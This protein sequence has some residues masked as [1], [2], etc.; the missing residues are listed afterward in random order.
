MY[1]SVGQLRGGGGLVVEY[2][3]YWL[4][5]KRGVVSCVSVCVCKRD[6]RSVTVSVSD[7]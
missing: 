2:I 6:E 3:G 1:V 5:V 7:T 4:D